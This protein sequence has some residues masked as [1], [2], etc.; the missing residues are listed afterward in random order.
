MNDGD[1][2]DVD[3]GDDGDGVGSNSDEIEIWTMF[4]Y[5]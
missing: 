4:D 5:Y 2:S 1:G 3:G